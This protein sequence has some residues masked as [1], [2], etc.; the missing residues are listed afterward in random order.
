M[1]VTYTTAAE[2]AAARSRT[3]ASAALDPWEF[4]LAAASICAV[5][6]TLTAY[7]RAAGTRNADVQSGPVVNLNTVSDAPSLE[8]IVGRVLPA[9]AD[10]RL[11]AR[12]LFSYLVQADGG[13][14]VIAEVR[15]LGRARVDAAVIDRTPAAAE[16]RLR[17]DDERARAQAAGRPA[18][19]SVA[20][21][22][23]ADL[24]EI[25]PSLAVRARRDVRGTLLLWLALYVLAFHGVSLLWRFRGV[26]GD[27]LLLVA[28]HLLTALGLAAMVSRPDP[29]RD[30]ILFSRYAQ[31]VIAG[32]TVAAA[33]SLVDLRT[34]VVRHLS[35]LP[36]LAAFALSIA[37]LVFGGGPAGSNA[38]VNLGPFQPIE[39][40][41]ILLALFLAGYFARNWELLRAVRTDA[42]GTVAVPRWLHLP[43]PRYV[44]PLL[45]GV[46]VALILFFFQKDLGPALMLSVAFLAAYGVARGRIG[47]VLAGAAL[48]A[49]GFYAGYRLGI[50]STLAERVRMWQ[51]PW[52]NAAR[53]GSQ[54][55]HALWA[56]SAG[57]SFGTGAGLGDTRYIPAGYTDLVLASLGEEFG[58]A[59]LLLAGSLYV[60]IIARALRLAG[61]ASSDYGFFLAT[62]V[63]LFLAIPVLLMASGTM[64]IVPLTGV[65]TPFLSYGG[66][67]MV[68]NFAA[69]G[70]LA[71][72][73][74]DEGSSADLAIFKAPIRWLGGTLAAAAV[75]LAVIAARVQVV[76]ADALVVRPHLG[77]QAD[78]IRRYQDNPRILDIVRRIPRG[79]VVDRNGLPL[80]TDDREV[81][82]KAAPAYARVGVQAASACARPDERCYPLGGRAFHLLGDVRTRRNWSASNTS[83]VERDDEGKLR[84]FD[85][86]ATAVEIAEPDGSAGSALRRDY[87]D[88]VPLLRHRYDPDH[89]SVKRIMEGHRE[90]RLTIDA[91]LQARVAAIVAEYA[92]KSATGH[93]AAVVIDPATGDLLASVSYPWPSDLP[94][95]APSEADADALLDRSRY[96]LYPPGS[97]FKLVTAAAALLRDTGAAGQTFTCSRL[98]DDRV[99][100]KISGYAR[101]VRDDEMDKTPHGTLDL[102]RALVVSCNA[103]FA[104]LAVRLGPQALA[105]AAQPAEISLARNNSTSRIRDTL[106]QVGYGQGEVVASPIRMARLVGA[107]ASDGSIRETRLDAGAPLP[108]S[109]PFV[110]QETATTLARYMRDVVLDGTG[111]ALRGSAMPIAGKTGTAEITGRPSHSW[112]V[113]FAPYGP[114][115]RRIAVAVIIENA[116]YG[117]A[118]AAPAA[119]EIV[120][121]AAALGLAR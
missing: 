23:P 15:A 102:H 11:A 94:A 83:F 86:H 117:G 69:L 89:P 91:R 61:R 53:G 5:L 49:A 84:G 62:M 77:V 41:R 105:Q 27:R 104:Q 85:D 98:P 28:A 30:A 56:M 44:V 81:V 96:G 45:T 8:P 63:A 40:I 99:G 39:A 78:G 22:T 48:L 57:G 115:A 50:S 6:L 51:S 24:T 112:F 33:V 109:H 65:V 75:A 73:R 31:G 95:A 47:L 113:G 59:G 107:I 54:I 18:P 32:L 58:L 67:A 35:Y 55:A 119:G 82:T 25:K 17:L 36:L 100:A 42:I 37:L 34:T 76:Q 108:P 10:R 14:R 60:V 2:R 71:S 90:L 16:Y 74:S 72:I 26:K 64:G 87:R 9:P 97:T 13:R 120:A 110:P 38:K 4:A 114:A 20:A 88:L 80:A 1:A 79:T 12:A 43:R 92:R 52:D 93:A 103:Y 111:R 121:A 66:S 68:A 29:V 19:T 21:L 3:R 116:G 101:P 106:P 46:G 70:L 118:A 7:S